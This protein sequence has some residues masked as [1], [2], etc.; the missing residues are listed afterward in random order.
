MERDAFH[1][2]RHHPFVFVLE[3][4]KIFCTVNICSFIAMIALKFHCVSF[5]FHR[6]RC[7]VLGRVCKIFHFKVVTNCFY[8]IFFGD[9][10]IPISMRFELQMWWRNVFRQ[11]EVMSIAMMRLNTDNVCA[12]KFIESQIIVHFF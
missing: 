7:R 5:N 11:A 3:F 4:V 9:N 10:F 2:I 1:L 6:C 12:H 8:L